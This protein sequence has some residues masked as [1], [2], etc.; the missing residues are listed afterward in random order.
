MM[1]STARERPILSPALPHSINSVVSY[2]YIV[3]HCSGA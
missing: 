3:D 1:S 2:C